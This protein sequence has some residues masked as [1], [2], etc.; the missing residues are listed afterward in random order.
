M[1]L[2]QGS[3]N[4]G[5]GTREGGFPCH[6]TFRNSS[7]ATELQGLQTINQVSGEMPGRDVQRIE[8]EAVATVS[9]M[10]PGPVF[11]RARHAG[12]LTGPDRPGRGLE[13]AA[14]FDF[15]EREAAAADDYQIKLAVGCSGSARENAIAFEHEERGCDQFSKTPQPFAALPATAWAR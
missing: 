5:Y 3:H 8:A 9:R 14:V 11:S 4:I 2:R 10:F 12:R 6:L 13:R 7:Q 15:D 1:R